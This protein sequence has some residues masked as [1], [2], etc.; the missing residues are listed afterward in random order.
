MSFDIALTHIMM[1]SDIYSSY[2]TLFF[3]K[4]SLSL[5]DVRNFLGNFLQNNYRGIIA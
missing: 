1:I 5:N 4:S 3:S 2:R